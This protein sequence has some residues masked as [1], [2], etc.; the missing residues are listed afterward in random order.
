MI[1]SDF[2]KTMGF[3]AAAEAILAPVWTEM[4][5]TFPGE[6]PFL[7]DDF[8]K[9]WLPRTGS[10]PELLPELLKAAAMTRSTPALALYAWVLHHGLVRAPMLPNLNKL[11]PPEK[12]MGDLAGMFTLAVSLAALPLIE[13]K[14]QELGIPRNYTDDLFTWLKGAIGVHRAG[15]D[16]QPGLCLNQYYWIRF[17]IDGT[18]FRIGRFEYLIHPVKDFVPAVFRSI[19]TGKLAVLAPD[20]WCFDGEG[21]RAAEGFRTT[22]R[23]ADGKFTGTPI[24]PDGRALCGKTLTIDTAEF[25]PVVTPWEWV[26]SIHIPAGGG[27]TPERVLASLRGAKAFFKQYFGRDIRM[28]CCSS[29][30][31][32]PDWETELPGSN[33]ASFI[34]LGWQIPSSTPSPTTGHFFVF[35]RSEVDYDR[36]PQTTALHRAFKRLHDK[37]RV[38]RGGGLVILTDDLD[39]ICDGYYRDPEKS[40]C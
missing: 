18:L 10:G 31:L 5:E 19:R 27:M 37:G 3:N 9:T 25:Q 7:A 16:G 1:L 17:Y 36:I 11:P 33:L 2:C 26:P 8:Q 35:G 23:Y 32:C 13:A 6:L 21:R 24:T 28:F 38:L 15:H 14:H 20:N 4:L 22:L 29:W 39:K 30:I 12:V 40:V 34:R